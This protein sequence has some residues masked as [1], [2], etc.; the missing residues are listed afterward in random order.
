[1]YKDKHLYQQKIEEM[2]KVYQEVAP[3]CWTQKQA[4]K[5]V[6]EHKAS[7]FFILPHTLYCA[8]QQVL[9][10]HKPSL[11][12]VKPSELRM[13]TE[14]LGRV[15]RKSESPD[16]HGWKLYDIC[17][18]TVR[19]PAPEFYCEPDTFR[20]ILYSW[21]RKKRER[22]RMLHASRKPKDVTPQ[23]SPSP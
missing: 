4:Y 2:M 20:H 10:G 15:T 12:F 11:K 18:E 6:V 5:A 13:Y 23:D 17:E 7:R 16:Y 14:L 22:Q 19:E 8:L 9:N 3:D 21:R 1:M